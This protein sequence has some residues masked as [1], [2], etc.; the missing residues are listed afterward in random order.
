MLYALQLAVGLGSVEREEL[1]RTEC[2]GLL[3]IP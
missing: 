2:L 1:R 3:V